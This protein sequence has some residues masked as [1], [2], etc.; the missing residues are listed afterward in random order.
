MVATCCV[1]GYVTMKVFLTPSLPPRGRNVPASACL[2][3][4]HKHLSIKVLPFLGQNRSKDH[5]KG[6]T[7]CKAVWSKI[8]A[9]C[10]TLLYK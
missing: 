8:Q 10:Q 6:L 3:P 7:V 4:M 5:V 9:H 1:M 2:C